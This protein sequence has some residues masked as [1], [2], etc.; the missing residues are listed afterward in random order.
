MPADNIISL[1]PITDQSVIEEL[2][3]RLD[4]IEH[5]LKFID[6]KP[7]TLCLEWLNPLTVA[8]NLLPELV[9]IAGGTPVLAT[10][11][12]PSLVV[13][14]DEIQQTDPDVI[15]IV[16]RGL[17]VEQ[18]MR[19]ISALLQEPGFADLQAVKNKRLYI[20]DGAA[21]FYQTDA[22]LVDAIEMLA[23]IIQPKQFI[24]GNEGEGWIKF[25]M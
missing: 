23:E 18:S 25:E 12:M 13:D 14:W 15:V 7:S 1:I 4:I 10:L 19:Q 20:A 11:G 6:K 16:A 17:S 21:Y 24:F 5:K 3:E 9:E 2:Q 8:G 22:G